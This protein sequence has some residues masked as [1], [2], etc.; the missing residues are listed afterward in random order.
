MLTTG[1]VHIDIGKGDAN[2]EQGLRKVLIGVYQII[3][4]IKYK[5][6]KMSHHTDL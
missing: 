1:V 6:I 4:S 3:A 2:K 5:R